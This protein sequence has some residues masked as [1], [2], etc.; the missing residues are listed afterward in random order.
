VGG[1][2]GVTVGMPWYDHPTWHEIVEHPKVAPDDVYWNLYARRQALFGAR[3]L[4]DGEKRLLSVLGR[5]LG[6]T[7]HLPISP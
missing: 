1:V 3:P 4:S 2:G 6:E 7:A 5:K